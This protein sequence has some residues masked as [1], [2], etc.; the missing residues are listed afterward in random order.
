MQIKTFG[1]D[2]DLD[3]SSPGHRLQDNLQ[4]EDSIEISTQ[5]IAS[6]TTPQKRKASIF[7]HEE[8]EISNPSKVWDKLDN[9][10][11]IEDKTPN[12]LSPFNT[13]NNDTFA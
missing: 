13:K 9:S 5:K 6:T 10:K 3:S 2:L 8:S 11:L 12:L 4:T 7:F 1:P